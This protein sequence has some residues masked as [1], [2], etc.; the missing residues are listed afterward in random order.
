M[1]RGTTNNPN[2]RPKGVPNKVNGNLREMIQKIIEDNIDSINDD[3]T[4]LE[5]KDRLVI[6]ERLMQYIIPKQQSVS[7]EAQIQAEYEAI[8]RLLDKVPNEAIEAITERL[9]KLNLLNKQNNE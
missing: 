5:P 8:E 9:I 1:K 6:L 2:G 4:N 3:L 7:V